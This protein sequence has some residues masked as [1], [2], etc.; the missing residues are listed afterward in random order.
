[1]RNR[2]TG[3][4]LACILLLGIGVTGCSGGAPV[5]EVRGSLTA[6]G[7]PV[8]KGP[9]EAWSNAWSKDLTA[10]SLNYSP[11]GSDVGLT[12]LATRQAYFAALDAPLTPE[13]QNRTKDVC[14]PA[15]A[16]SVPVS[17]TSI[18]VALN[19]PSL[20]NVK[21]TR[22]VLAGIFSGTITRWD[23]PEIA[24]LNPDIALPSDDI[25][26]IVATEPSAETA[27]A[28]KYLSADPAWTTGAA[29]TWPKINNDNAVTVKKHSDLADKVDKTAGGI[30]FM[31][32]GSIG[33]RFETA[34]LS[35]GGSYVRMS[36]DSAAV[37]AQEGSTKTL[38]TGVE[39]TLPATSDQGYALGVVGY[40]AFCRE[41]SNHQLSTLVKS[42]GQFVLSPD[43]QVSSSYFAN[44]ASPSE[45]AVRESRNLIDTIGDAQ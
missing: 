28:T 42:W 26:P 20:R 9:I 14:G 29:D 23:A 8:Q 45:E 30:A 11:D 13:Q 43:G 40:Q 22:A 17:V 7:T 19:N 4:A 24:G 6:I 21:L 35:F 31:D 2:S 18:G 39:F 12:A 5:S 37:A 41:Y 10:T 32:L 3:G 33:T 16:F 15:G 25:A 1:M 36:K 34:L 44:V 38:P 27:A